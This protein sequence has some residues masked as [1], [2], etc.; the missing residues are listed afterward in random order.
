MD[1]DV[2]AFFDTVDDLFAGRVAPATRDAARHALV[3]MNLARM[4]ARARLAELEAELDGSSD[5]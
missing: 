3:D 5:G 2:R 1:P 4:R